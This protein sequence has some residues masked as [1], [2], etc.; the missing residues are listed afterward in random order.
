MVQ[1]QLTFFQKLGMA[2]G[3]VLVLYSL[4]TIL[5]K[6]IARHSFILRSMKRL[7][8]ARTNETRMFQIDKNN[9]GH[10]Q[11]QSSPRSESVTDQV[12]RKY[13]QETPISHGKVDDSM[14]SVSQYEGGKSKY[15]NQKA[16]GNQKYN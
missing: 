4:L 10:Q 6:P 13:P 14:E 2:G 3:L 11:D 12:K 7:Y 9:H 15:G 5:M 16:H 8:Y 1:S